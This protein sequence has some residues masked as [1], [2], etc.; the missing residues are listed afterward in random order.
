[1]STA[2][3]RPARVF[4]LLLGLGTACAPGTTNAPRPGDQSVTAADIEKNPS[5]PLEQTLQ[6]KFPGVNV[7][8]TPSGVSVT[9]GGP[10]SFSGDTGPLYVLD[11]SPITPGPGGVLTG[12]NPYDIESIKVLRNPADVAIYGMRGANGVILI[13]TK[14][15]K[16]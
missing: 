8:G 3:R 1:M 15:P 5:Q 16:R 4:V 6:S 10:S 13:S 9:I 14:R 2:S 12:L 7:T 11:G